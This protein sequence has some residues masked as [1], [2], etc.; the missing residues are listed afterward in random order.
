LPNGV[1]VLKYTDWPL[2]TVAAEAEITGATRAG[3]TVTVVF[4]TAVIEPA[5]SKTQ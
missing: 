2:K 1:V 3:L 4:V 5:T